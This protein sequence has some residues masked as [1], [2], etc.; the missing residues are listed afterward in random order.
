MSM[1]SL[2]EVKL[3]L[4]SL[5]ISCYESI[6]VDKL[7]CDFKDVEGK[8]I[9]FHQ[10]GY[11]ALEDFLLSI[12]DT[13][14]VV[15]RGPKAI[16]YNVITDKSKHVH[17][18][19]RKQRKPRK[20]SNLTASQ[21][22]VIMHSFSWSAINRPE[23]RETPRRTPF[24]RNEQSSSLQNNRRN[25]PLDG[26]KQSSSLQNNRRNAPLDGNKQSSSLQNNRRNAP[27][28]KQ[29]DETDTATDGIKDGTKKSSDR[30]LSP[31]PAQARKRVDDNT[32]ATHVNINNSETP[33]SIPTTTQNRQ[34]KE[35]SP[36]KSV[37]IYNDSNEIQNN[38][39]EIK[40]TPNLL[41]MFKELAD[42]ENTN[43]ISLNGKQTTKMYVK[44]IENISCNILDLL[45]DLD[46]PVPNCASYDLTICSDF[47]K[48]LI[49]FG[50]KIP[51]IELPKNH[52]AG[53]R[54]EIYIAQ[55]HSPFK[56]W[57]Q[58]KQNGDTLNTLMYQIGRWYKILEPDD[59]RIPLN[60]LKPGQVC[61][62]PYT[63]LWHRAKI[64][65]HPV[66]NKIKVC[67]VDYGTV[68]EVDIVKI[69]YLTEHFCRLPAQALRG[70]LSY[71]KPRQLH[72]TCE[73]VNN[74]LGFVT[75]TM[76]F[77]KISEINVEQNIC[78]LVICNTCEND[79]VV[80]INTALIKNGYASY[81]YNWED[82]N[83]KKCNGKRTHHPRED[84]PTFEM[85][86][87]GEYPNRDE[88]I[89]L[90]GL[91]IDYETI[92]DHVAYNTST[93]LNK[94]DGASTLLQEIPFPLLP[95][96]P[97][98]LDII[99]ELNEALL[100]LFYYLFLIVI[101]TS[102]N[103]TNLVTQTWVMRIISNDGCSV[104]QRQEDFIVSGD[105]NCP[106]C[107]DQLLSPFPCQLNA[108]SSLCE[109]LRWLLR[110]CF[111]LKKYLRKDFPKQI[112]MHYRPTI[113]SRG[114]TTDYIVSISAAFLPVKIFG[115][116]LPLKSKATAITVLDLSVVV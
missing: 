21:R 41:S 99:L 19:V 13:V 79:V 71:I 111:V 86:E 46:K 105:E 110:C 48:D 54:L 93:I 25:A 50:N 114:N 33:F 37:C 90:E 91:G 36:S 74:F 9:P 69:K 96:N 100:N 32:N 5:V 103:D 65:G 34:Q 94:H 7:N 59:M 43:E 56:F 72:W 3:I 58:M 102:R 81:D 18:M 23:I 60:C 67:S 14:T 1:D 40:P 66:G 98:F 78:Y 17:D 52:L 104:F 108:G 30:F 88:L 29:V 10:F 84:F 42:M 51:A 8:N 27:V 28:R 45:K 12:P 115:A 62:A 15:G 53:S 63:D 11:Q 26:N 38:M 20:Y 35:I 106:N 83:I 82:C 85:L 73:A 77:A 87:S 61:A 89:W 22:N 57:F 70:S 4:K 80:Q 95:T 16:V 2:S 112:E 55:V 64:I 68:F 113:A 31:I 76:V 107:L 116:M 44:V 6:T 92:Y 49:P 101:N 39:K 109:L 97:F 47:P 24:D 75:E